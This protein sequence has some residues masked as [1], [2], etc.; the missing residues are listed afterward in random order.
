[1]RGRVIPAAVSAALVMAAM[2]VA[3]TAPV[4]TLTLAPLAGA[5]GAAALLHP[6]RRGPVATPHSLLVKGQY[7]SANWGGFIDGATPSTTS[8][9]GLTGTGAT[10]SG[11][12]ATWNV[13]QLQKSPPGS[14]ESSWVGI[15]GVTGTENLLQAGTM[16][17][18]SG[19]RATYVAFVEDYP[20]PPLSIVE[21]STPAPVRPGD[22]ITV[23][24]SAPNTVTVTDA[25]QNWTFGPTDMASIY[26]ADGDTYYPPDQSTAEW[27]VEDPTCGGSLC[28]F[29]NFSPETFGTVQDSATA[30]PTTGSHTPLESVIVNAAGQ[31]QVSVSPTAIGSGGL[32]TSTY[33]SFTVTRVST[34]GGSTPGHGHKGK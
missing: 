27:I 22:T 31:Q 21:G 29:A 2:P 17:Y 4:P 19:R 30:I 3:L 16:E 28:T 14:Y 26:E 5:P 15:G 20:N 32:G 24:V 8:S 6:F 13:P 23:T 25:T 33:S 11:V 9:T 7:Y 1:M 18:F 10:F 34:S 12:A